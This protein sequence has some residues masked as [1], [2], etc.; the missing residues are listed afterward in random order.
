MKLEAAENNKMKRIIVWLRNDL[1]LHDNYCLD[2]AVKLKAARKEVLPVFS[3]D[4]RFTTNRVERYG[5]QKCGAI[6]ARFLHETVVN[7]RKN[8]EAIG[9]QLLVTTERP[10]DFLP[11]LIDANADN[12]IVF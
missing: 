9:S 3:F 12:A 7:L 5:I 8:L 11:K 2:W 4:P 1:R 6:R 10:E